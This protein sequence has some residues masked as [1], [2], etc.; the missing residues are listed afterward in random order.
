MIT[1]FYSAVYNTQNN[2]IKTT[3][4]FFMPWRTK[5][6][7]FIKKDIKLYLSFSKTIAL[8]CSTDHTFATSIEKI[9]DRINVYL[10]NATQEIFE[11]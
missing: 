2:I 9:R 3:G 6:Q 11:I 1:K 7:Y 4:N 5:C 8:T 10:Y